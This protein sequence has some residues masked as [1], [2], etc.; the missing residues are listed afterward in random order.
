[1]I[2]KEKSHPLGVDDS[3]NKKTSTSK[4]KISAE[5]VKHKGLWDAG[6][7]EDV[8]TLGKHILINKP[9]IPISINTNIPRRSLINIIDA[10][11]GILHSIIPS[12]DRMVFSIKDY[13]NSFYSVKT[14]L[15]KRFGKPRVYKVYKG[16]VYRGKVYKYKY[17]GSKILL[18]HKHFH[19]KT[20][21]YYKWH[22]LTL[23]DV[24]TEL[25]IIIKEILIS[26]IFHEEDR[27]LKLVEFTLDFYPTNISYLK[28]LERFLK[29]HIVLKYSRVG[30]YRRVKGSDYQAKDHN[31][32][33]GSKGL[34]IYKAPKY[35]P[36]NVRVELQALDPFL[37]SHGFNVHSLPIMPDSINVLEYIEL[38]HTLDE[39]GLHKL[40]N[41]LSKNH[42]KKARGVQYSDKISKATFY[43]VFRRL[44]LSK[45]SRTFSGL[46]TAPAAF[47]INNIFKK[48]K[49]SKKN[50]LGITHQVDCFFNKMTGWGELFKKLQESLDLNVSNEK[51]KRIPT[52]KLGLDSVYFY[53][54]DLLE[55]TISDSCCDPEDDFDE[56]EE[57]NEDDFQEDYEEDDDDE[58]S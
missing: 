47:M 3:A 19:P 16:K 43:E 12:L 11:Q 23:T 39:T 5:P 57:L 46:S 25:Q 32:M 35:D 37:R 38:R 41:A 33:E 6:E 30:A 15:T 48:Y 52:S 22:T 34:R 13:K 9:Q 27:V 55:N 14:S 29:C 20:E 24:S 18:L 17:K 53:P 28:L 44:I 40:C 21:D 58:S 2:R 50:Q 51:L 42:Y 26:D 4:K 54:D 7:N 56:Y 45:T 31:L 10:S 1:M 36:T 8:E 49:K